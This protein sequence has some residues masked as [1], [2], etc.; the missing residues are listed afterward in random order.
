MCYGIIVHTL[1]RNVEYNRLLL[2]ILE[3]S[4]NGFVIK[5]RHKIEFE[6]FRETF[7][8]VWCSKVL[9]EHAVTN[10]RNASNS[11]IALALFE[12]SS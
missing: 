7:R 4:L 6:N 9:V 2:S 5:L 10:I 3:P 8:F 12:N 11:T 1:F